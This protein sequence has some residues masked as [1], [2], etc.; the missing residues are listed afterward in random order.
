MSHPLVELRR[1]LLPANMSSSGTV[2]K[3]ENGGITV[4]TAKGVII[5]RRAPGDANAY[6]IGTAVKIENDGTL[7]G[8]LTTG[9]IY[10][11]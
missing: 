11:V 8:R 4:A 7:R 10:A 5:A 1:L 9:I 3:V 2:I 6:P